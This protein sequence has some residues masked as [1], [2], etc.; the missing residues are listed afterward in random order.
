M[1][2]STRSK[3]LYTSSEAILNGLADDGG[4]FVPESITSINFNTD[5]LAYNYKQTS[6]KVLKHFFDDFT[7]D[8]INYVINKA[9][10]KSN[11]INKIYD[12]KNFNNHTYLE[13]YHGPTLAFKDMALTMLP[14]LMDVAIKKNN[15]RAC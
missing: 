5:W 12:I 6:F 7:N 10:S 9:Y 2:K 14:H 13:L 3:K 4:L 8:E 15:Y 11:F 1:Y